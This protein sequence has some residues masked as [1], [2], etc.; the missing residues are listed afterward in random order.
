MVRKRI[1]F[2]TRDFHYVITTM[3]TTK[4]AGIAIGI[5][6]A[7]IPDEEGV[8]NRLKGFVQLGSGFGRFL[9]GL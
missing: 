6:N 8:P 9:V 4:K 5:I 1:S 2:L 7:R 3:S